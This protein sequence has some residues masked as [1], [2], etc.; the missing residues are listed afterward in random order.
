MEGY[1]TA[2]AHG[3][4]DD[5]QLVNI[6]LDTVYMNVAHTG[7]NQADVLMKLFDERR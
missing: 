4:S 2:T 3:L 6:V 5:C 1:L 7:D